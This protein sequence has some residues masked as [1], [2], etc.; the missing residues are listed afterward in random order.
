MRTRGVQ[1]ASN[2]IVDDGHDYVRRLVSYPRDDQQEPLDCRHGKEL[3]VG[4]KTIRRDGKFAEAVDQ[5]AHNC[6]PEAKNLILSREVGLTRGGGP[7]GAGGQPARCEC[8]TTIAR[9]FCCRLAA[10]GGEGNKALYVRLL[11]G[12]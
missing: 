12:G 10:D 1:G 3:K 6:G 4:E 2:Q 8:D 5:I 7:A 11:L 9:S